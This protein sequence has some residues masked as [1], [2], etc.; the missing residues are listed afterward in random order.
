MKT[1]QNTNENSNVTMD[2]VPQNWQKWLNV[3]LTY[4]ELSRKAITCHGVPTTCSVLLCPLS[5]LNLFFVSVNISRSYRPK[6]V[7]IFLSV[8]RRSISSLTRK[9]YVWIKRIEPI[10]VHLTYNECF[11]W[12]IHCNRV[13]ELCNSKFFALYLSFYVQFDNNLNQNW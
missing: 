5:I 6:K 1:R 13:L 12:E 8:I 9:E 3:T 7:S 2:I 4:Q 10:W 11:I